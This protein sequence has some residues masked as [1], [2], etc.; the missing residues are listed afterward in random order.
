MITRVKDTEGN[1]LHTYWRDNIGKTVDI[2]IDAEGMAEGVLEV[3][4]GTWTIIVGAHRDRFE[5]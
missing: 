1:R 5:E 2:E 4:P 3:V